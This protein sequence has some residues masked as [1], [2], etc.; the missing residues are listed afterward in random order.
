MAL[1]FSLKL[2]PGAPAPAWTQPL[3]VTAGGRGLMLISDGAAIFVAEGPLLRWT[4]AAR[5]GLA[6]W[7]VR[8]EH[9]HVVDGPL[10]LQFDLGALV[11]GAPPV[12]A[13]AYDMAGDRHWSAQSPAQSFD[14]FA[15]SATTDTRFSAPVALGRDDEHMSLIVLASDGRF[16]EVAF[17]LVRK[18]TARLAPPDQVALFSGEGC[19]FYLSG[20]SVVTVAQGLAQ[21]AAAPLQ[22]DPQAWLRGMR[23]AEQG[24]G[25]CPPVF[26]GSRDDLLTVAAQGAQPFV[27]VRAA[28]GALLGCPV[29]MPPVS[30]AHCRQDNGIWFGHVV[31]Q[32]STGAYYQA[33]KLDV[34]GRANA[35]DQIDAILV[36]ELAAAAAWRRTG[37]LAD[38]VTFAPAASPLYAACGAWMSG[39]PTAATALAPENVAPHLHA[40][41]GNGLDPMAEFTLL[42][43][44][45][46]LPK[47][48]FVE[49]MRQAGYALPELLAF[50]PA[51]RLFV[52]GRP[53]PADQLGPLCDTLR[54]AGQDLEAMFEFLFG[55]FARAMDLGDVY[56]PWG[57]GKRTSYPFLFLLIGNE[58]N[59]LES[60]PRASWQEKRFDLQP[61]GLPLRWNIDT[62]VECVFYAIVTAWVP[63]GWAAVQSMPAGTDRHAPELAQL[64]SRVG[65]VAAKMK[66]C[67]RHYP[68]LL[69]TWDDGL[70]GT[71]LNQPAVRSL[72]ASLVA[73]VKRQEIT[74]FDLLH[75]D[76]VI[77][78]WRTMKHRYDLLGRCSGTA[79]T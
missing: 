45:A 19:V 55:E 44:V 25:L 34:F 51:S 61:V 79:A 72:L 52:Y 50:I 41:R 36:S 30:P 56:L 17:D 23:A 49:A 78:R 21:R 75:W 15:V 1:T 6:G 31:V 68:D 32:D 20:G 3:P 33:Y 54:A 76:D 9:L 39:S 62:N 77:E 29:G 57:A 65:E 28:P 16:V 2:P 63:D 42:A 69:E 12:P 46:D 58:E 7:L 71:D 74:L 66:F 22:G 5:T 13:N 27:A 48:A 73:E 11:P 59:I 8:G 38:T 67:G 24:V 53:L 43:T 26:V 10:L 70:P 60:R 37:G 18:S 14:Q 47:A 64:A 4:V 35:D 40:L